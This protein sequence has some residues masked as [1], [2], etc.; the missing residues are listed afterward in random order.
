MTRYKKPANPPNLRDLS[1][2]QRTI[3]LNRRDRHKLGE[4]RLHGVKRLDFLIRRVKKLI[5]KTNPDLPA[6][7][8]SLEG[9]EL[10]IHFITTHTHRGIPKRIDFPG[11][12]GND[13]KRFLELLT[14]VR[15][16]APGCVP[17]PPLEIFSAADESRA[18]PPA[19]APPGL[20][21]DED[22]YSSGE[23]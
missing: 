10:I 21:E 8:E 4:V 17:S 14:E 23:E 19:Q 15:V 22:E 7:Y 18:P 9:H 3:A 2:A 12:F 16:Y 1:P 6:G 5:K 13:F 11:P 20:E